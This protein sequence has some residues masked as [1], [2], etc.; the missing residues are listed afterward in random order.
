MGYSDADDLDA[1]IVWDNG[2]LQYNPPTAYF[3]WT[4]GTADMVLFSVRR[5]SALIGNPD[6][7]C[8]YAIEPGDILAP[9]IV[10]NTAPLIWIPAEYFGLATARTATATIGDELDALDIVCQLAG[11]CNGDGVVDQVDLALLLSCYGTGVCCDVNGDGITDQ[12]D[13][14]LLL[15]AYGLSC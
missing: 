10:P 13:L 14:A 9:P 3:Q 4:F 8:G 2:N 7:G 15:S 6:S 12:A 5:G 11:D 1:L